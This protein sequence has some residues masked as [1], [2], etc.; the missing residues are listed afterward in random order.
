MRN[1]LVATDADIRTF[2]TGVTCNKRGQRIHHVCVTQSY[3]PG[4]SYPLAPGLGGLLPNASKFPL[5]LEKGLET[6][7][8]IMLSDLEM[9]RGKLQMPTFAYNT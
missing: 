5:C 1:S 4:S 2:R 6:E 3:I 8:N 9:C 7:D